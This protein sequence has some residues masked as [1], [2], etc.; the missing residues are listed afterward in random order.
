MDESRLGASLSLLAAFAAAAAGCQAVPEV[1][2]DGAVLLRV[3][4]APGAPLP[5]ELRVS[6]YDDGGALWKNARI[7]EQGALRPEAG[8][9]LGTILVQ[10][11]RGSRG[12]LRVHARGFRSGARVLDGLLIVAPEARPAGTFDLTLAAAEPPDLDGDGVPDAIDDCPQEP[13]PDQGGCAA[14]RAGGAADAGVAADARAAAPDAPPADRV[15]PADA[16]TAPATPNGQACGAPDECASGVCLEGVCCERACPLCQTCAA[17]G[18]AGRCTP[19]PRLGQETSP[20]GG[21]CS[22]SHA[23]DGAGACKGVQ[24]TACVLGAECLSGFCVDGVCCGEACVGPCRSCNQPGRQGLCQ[25]HAEGTDPE[26]NCSGGAACNG[27]GA[28]GPPPS[29]KRPNG[30]LCGA[31]GECQSGF[32]RDGVCCDSACDQPCQTCATGACQ[33]VTRN[34]DPPE[35]VAPRSCNPQGKC[36]MSGG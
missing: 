20:A 24:G 12:R 13:N 21:G 14:A 23:C 11:G 22:R 5:D 15:P 18:A 28:C 29:G 33:P 31:A 8:A 26:R 32:C 30:Q 25:A 4:A 1:P 6:V 7:P 10:P 17:A 9:R 35:C 19:R 27:A 34:E 16:R 3:S 36:V 2:E